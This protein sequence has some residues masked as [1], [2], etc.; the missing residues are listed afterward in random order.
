MREYICVCVRT[1]W[2]TVAG[3]LCFMR[4]TTLVAAVVYNYVTNYTYVQ[5]SFRLAILEDMSS[6]LWCG[7]TRPRCRI[8]MCL[9]TPIRSSRPGKLCMRV[10]ERETLK[11]CTAATAKCLHGFS[12]QTCPT[13]SRLQFCMLHSGLTPRLCKTSLQVIYILRRNLQNFFRRSRRCFSE[14]QSG[15]GNSADLQVLS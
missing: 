11:K 12:W 5:C 7:C 14:A 8:R 13:P 9:S 1:W 6:L 3:Q 4:C 10:R 15:S 2:E